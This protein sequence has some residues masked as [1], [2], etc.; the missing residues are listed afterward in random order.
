MMNPSPRSALRLLFSSLL[1]PW[2]LLG[3]AAC[4]RQPDAPKP[5]EQPGGSSAPSQS[6]EV[7]AAEESSIQVTGSQSRP[8]ASSFDLYSL[9]LK[10]LQAKLETCQR[11]DSC[12]GQDLE[13]GKLKRLLGYVVD[14]QRGDVLLLGVDDPQ[15]PAVL[16]EDFVIA[17]RNAW[18]RYDEV[19]GNVR[20]YSY[21]GCDIRPNSEVIDKLDALMDQ[22]NT[23]SSAGAVRKVISAWRRTCMVPQQ[24]SVHGVPF[25][26]HFGKVMVEADYDMKS[27]TD[28]TDDPGVPGFTSLASIRRDRHQQAFA[29]GQTP[30]LQG[31][32]N[33]YWLSPGEYNYI[34]ADGIVLIKQAS[35][36]VQ[37]NPTTVDDSGEIVDTASSDPLAERWVASF[38]ILYD[39]IAARR[40]IYRELDNLFRAFALAK[41]LRFRKGVEAAG[42]DLTYFLDDFPIVGEEVPREVDG[43][44]TVDHIERILENE[45]SIQTTRLWMPGCGGVGMEIEP[46]D[47][48]FEVVPQLVDLRDQVLAETVPAPEPTLVPKAPPVTVLAQNQ[49]LQ[50]IN[51][52]NHPLVVTLVDAD[53]QVQLFDGLTRTSYPRLDAP[54]I[55]SQVT[56]LLSKKGASTVYVELE[57]FP[58]DEQENF[59]RTSESQIAESHP[60][61]LFRPIPGIADELMEQALFGPGIE[62]SEPDPGAEP[63]PERQDD[64]RLQD[65]SRGTVQ[66]LSF[67][68]DRLATITITAFARDQA[69]V[70]AFLAKVEARFSDAPM[71]PESVIQIIDQA[72]RELMAEETYRDYLREQGRE[73]ELRIRAESDLGGR[74]FVD[75]GTSSRLRAA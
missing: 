2:L 17:L 6:A 29:R 54:Q 28:G 20:H 49:R 70:D 33:R 59:I 14:E 64:V 18:G 13:L 23:S 15:W 66:F 43:R 41:I 60:D 24:V 22:L 1:L 21:P 8:Q 37:T 45:E 31:G 48:D 46:E 39:K 38:S 32:M 72:R 53:S 3:L 71:L 69:V 52:N 51:K 44:P 55:L 19:K 42:L 68:Q 61:V 65:W 9:S 62:L 10:G 57:D 12:T 36:R 11:D 47:K 75:V 30:A 5:T 50:Q 58:A 7:Q 34:E 35:V 27:L 4:S 63:P 67:V 16:V 26:T 73:G 40:P 74:H 56:E 25:D